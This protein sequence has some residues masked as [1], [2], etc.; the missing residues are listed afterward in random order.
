MLLC[1]WWLYIQ[2]A[3]SGIVFPVGPIP[4]CR[5]S[6]QTF[7]QQASSHQTFTQEAS[8][9][10]TFIQQASSHQTFTQEASSHQTFIQQASSH[11]TFIQQAS[12]HQTF[13][14]E[15]LQIGIEPT[16]NTIPDTIDCVYSHQPHDNIL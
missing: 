12:S 15:A 13:T 2:S 1:G 7:I 4:V 10:Q 8:S 6:H 16:G 5:A 11:Q 9:H 3:V 14:Q